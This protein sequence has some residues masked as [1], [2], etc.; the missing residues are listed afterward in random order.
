MTVPRIVDRNAAEVALRE[1]L[2]R[3]TVARWADLL[4][5]LDDDPLAFFC[6]HC[7]VESILGSG[8][9][10]PSAFLVIEPLSTRDEALTY[11]CCKCAATGTRWTLVRTILDR[12]DLYVEMLRKTAGR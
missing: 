12:P 8:I 11:S 10:Y 2:Q 1:K 4:G 9:E 6:P 7:Q 3:L 5:G